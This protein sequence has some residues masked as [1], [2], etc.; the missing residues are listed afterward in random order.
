MNTDDRLQSAFADLANQAA[1]ADP[2]PGLAELVDPTAASPAAR[3][4]RPWLRAVAAAAVIVGAVG[5][6]AGVQRGDD[7]VAP[8][9]SPTSTTAAS[10][11]TTAT[12]TDDAPVTDITEVTTTTSAAV[13]TSDLHG[14]LVA[15]QTGVSITTDGPAQTVTAQP[16]IVAYSSPMGIVYQ[17]S[18]GD[19]ILAGSEGEVRL[20][21]SGSLQQIA[22]ID[23]VSV[24]IVIERTEVPG[25][26]AFAGRVVAVAVES[27][28]RTVLSERGDIT[29]Y[30]ISGDLTVI[31]AAEE[32]ATSV[33]VLEDGIEV[34][35]VAEPSGGV[36][37]SGVAD[38]S[39]DT[40]RV[41]YFRNDPAGGSGTLIV[42]HPDGSD[43]RSYPIETGLGMWLDLTPSHAG[44]SYG[45]GV[46]V[47]GFGFVDLANDEQQFP[48]F[49][50]TVTLLQEPGL[51]TAT[52]PASSA[53]PEGWRV[54]GVEPDAFLNVRSDP[55]TDSE[56][57]GRLF[58]GDTNVQPTGS[59]VVDLDG[60]GWFEV[61][62]EDG[63][64][65]YAS[66]EF[67]APPTSWEVGFDELACGESGP[68]VGER[69]GSRATVV[70]GWAYSFGADC[71]R[72]VIALGTGTASDGRLSPADVAPPEVSGGVDQFG[73]RV[74]LP[75]VTDVESIARNAVLG[76]RLALIAQSLEG[77]TDFHAQIL[78][79]GNADVWVTTLSS[80]ARVII[81]VA[82]PRP[83]GGP[84]IGD[85]NTVLAVPID[86]SGEGIRG[87][88]S[89]IGYARW[90]EA[91]GGARLTRPDGS[92]ASGEIDGPSVRGGNGTSS[93]ALDAPYA[94]TWGEFTV[95]VEAD[96]GDYELFIGDDCFLDGSDTS[97]D[98]GVT[99]RFTVVD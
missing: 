20:D 96:P 80:P 97:V 15:D 37:R 26:E 14:Y 42:Q 52:A 76:G 74:L 33:T 12:V 57:M 55:G 29:R 90:F 86:P 89:V 68:E 48:P 59:G 22:D 17:A 61:I 82:N 87:S 41:A 45:D 69:S 77:Q 91:H 50:G 2:E 54:R 16:A 58:P 65:G 31:T 38:A 40:P 1:G 46:S 19:I 28:S 18:N 5:A 84:V 99:Q 95:L 43:S 6:I 13:P 47:S 4:P 60:A 79:I 7:P 67:L 23:G 92:P 36:L 3:A 51:N 85:G 39:Q 63:T 71:D 72:Y 62:L 75:G 88:V 25:A 53:P 73:V 8:A 49:P 70:N 27:N 10:T 98:C 32:E 9:A 81:D 34:F 64:V 35:S 21:A 94:T 56:L 83:N 30:H 78:G 93:A 11:S 66:S 44:I 24:A